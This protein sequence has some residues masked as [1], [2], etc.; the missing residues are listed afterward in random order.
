LGV[1]RVHRQGNRGQ[2]ASGLCG[3]IALLLAASPPLWGAVYQCTGPDGSTVFADSPCGADAKVIIVRPQAPMSNTAP[4]PGA[5]RPATSTVNRSK[6][7]STSDAQAALN[8]SHDAD[9]LKCQA[10]EY[11]AWY[12]AQNPKPS[13]EQSDAKMSQIVESCWLSTHLL[14]A[15]DNLA[16]NPN[17]TVVT[18]KAPQPIAGSA[19]MASAPAAA[20]APLQ[21]SRSRQPEEAARWS[22]Y[23]AC[24]SQAF[25]DWSST[26][27]HEPDDAE[28]REAQSRTDTDCRAQ[29][30]IP[31][32]GAAIIT[33]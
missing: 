32:G 24:R 2:R 25:L 31:G 1:Q 12:Q 11:G 6:S 17:V 20:G 14:T 7:G 27:G 16:V 4:L 13:R 29:F 18:R 22:G 8:A 26:L 21:V 23:Y 5:K 3:A 9:A 30:S 19:G 15:Q 33:D 10:R 28:T